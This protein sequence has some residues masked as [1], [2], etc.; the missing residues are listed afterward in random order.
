MKTPLII[1]VVIGVLVLIVGCT[2]QATITEVKSTAPPALED[3]STA[4]PVLSRQSYQVVIEDGKLM[5][6][7]VEINAGDTVEWVNKDEVRYTLLFSGSEERL[8]VGGTFEQ[9]FTEPGIARYIVAVVEE[10]R[11]D[12]QEREL[13]GT[14]I[15]N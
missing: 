4:V 2:Q 9:Q 6:V 3:D 8:S 15:V 14:V 12:N 13:Q 10:D 11:D 5:P 7:D 1:A